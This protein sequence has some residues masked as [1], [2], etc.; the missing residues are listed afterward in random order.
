M[1]VAGVAGHTANF[2]IRVPVVMDHTTTCEFMQN[3]LFML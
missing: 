3:A 2:A 1:P